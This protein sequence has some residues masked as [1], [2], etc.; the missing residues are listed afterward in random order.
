M[1]PIAG[2]KLKNLSL[3]D[4]HCL[5]VMLSERNISRA[6]RITGYSQPKLSNSLAGVRRALGDPLLI[7]TG[8][9]M[10]LT[11]QA[12]DL[13]A[14]ITKLL[15]MLAE[16]GQTNG[17]DPLSTK[18]RF[19]LLVS[20]MASCLIL[21]Q[22][23]AELQRRAPSAAFVVRTMYN[24]GSGLGASVDPDLEAFDLRIGWIN[25]LPPYWC[26]TKLFEDRLVVAGRKGHPEL[27]P[28][29]SA[30]KLMD[31]AH[32]SIATDSLQIPSFTDAFLAEQRLHRRIVATISNFTLA[33]PILEKSDMVALVPRR[34]AELYLPE[35]DTIW[36]DCPVEFISIATSMAWHP[37]VDSMPE[38]Q[39]LRAVVRDVVAAEIGKEVRS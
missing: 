29:I 22:L 5:Y 23:L 35:L 10:V 27:C 36:I 19:Y 1:I 15:P 28:G 25:K 24:V 38:Y 39:W 26:I 30:E 11:D 21:P 13:L 8:S 4:L 18:F 6:A 17:F 14:Q 34:Y 20:D 9:K 32:L 2:S 33:K 7:R 37:R 3:K 16:L 31:L 12:Q